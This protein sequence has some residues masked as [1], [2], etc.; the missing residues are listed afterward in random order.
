M[1]RMINNSTSSSTVHLQSHVSAGVDDISQWMK[2][3]RL[4]L[5]STKLK[6]SSAHTNTERRQHQI[7][8]VLLMVR[9]DAVH[10]VQSVRN[11]YPA[12]VYLLHLQPPS[13]SSISSLRLLLPS[14]ASVYFLHLQPLST[15][16]ISSLRLLPPSPAS[17]YFFHLQVPSIF[18]PQ[19]S[20]SNI[21]RLSQSSFSPP[22]TAIV[23]FP[24]FSSVHKLPPS[25]AS[26]YSP[27]FHPRPGSQRFLESLPL[28]LC[29]WW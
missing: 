5:N 16:S 11:L 23:Y 19:F 10:P 28:G 13:T 1:I 4:Q 6:S 20:S 25:A 26:I 9:S 12:S 24:S 27:S 29:T 22:S 21:R 7:P 14:P 2:A 15:S 3:N 18:K 8:M 17:V